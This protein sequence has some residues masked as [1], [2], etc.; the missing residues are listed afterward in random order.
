MEPEEHTGEQ[1]NWIGGMNVDVNYAKSKSDI[2]E[3]LIAVLSHINIVVM[4]QAV[5]DPVPIDN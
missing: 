5:G 4:R 1:V 2:V 3:H